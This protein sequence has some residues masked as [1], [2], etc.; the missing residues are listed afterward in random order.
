MK[1]TQSSKSSKSSKSNLPLVGTFKCG[2]TKTGGVTAVEVEAP[3]KKAPK[4]P[5]KL[6]KCKFI[7]EML[8]DGTHRLSAILAA[9][10]KEYPD[11]DSAKTMATIRCRPAHMRAAGLKPAWLPEE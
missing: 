1:S 3:T 11:A 7:D 6:S 2:K 8:A 4:T 10:M 9:T 5:G